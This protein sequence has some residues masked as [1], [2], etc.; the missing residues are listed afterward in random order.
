MA[1][2]LK[3]EKR[4]QIQVLIGLG[5]S[6]RRISATIGIDRDTVSKYRKELKRNP[7]ESIA[8]IPSAI[9]NPPKVPT[10]SAEESAQNPPEV[11][12][13]IPHVSTN[14]TQL[15]SHTETVRAMFLK[16]L[17]AQRIFQDLVEEYGYR[18]SYDSVKRYVRKLRKRIRGFTDRLEH[19]P[20][21]E[22]QVDF[23]KA[24]CKVL[25]DGKYQRPWLFK[26]T[27]SCSKHA[28]EE[29]VWSQDIE[30]FL[31]CHERAFKFF[32]GV[33]EIVTLDNLRAGVLKACLYDPIINQTYLA[34]ATHWGFAANPCIPRMPEHKG[35]VERDIGYT[36]HNALDGREFA[37]LDAAN[38]FLRHWSRRWA[39]TRIHGTTKCQ[40]WK[41]FCEVEQAHLQPL[42]KNDY[43]YFTAAVRKVDVN[44]LVEVDKRYYGVPVQYIG[45]SV[46]A[47]FNQKWVK[48]YFQSQLVITHQ[49]ILLA[50]KMS[51]PASC[52]P[53]W[54]H[55]DLESQERYYCRMA[56]Q[57][58]PAMHTL[59]YKALCSDDVLAI[60]RVRGFLSLAKTYGNAVAEEAASRA[61]LLQTPK[62]P[63]LQQLCI[64]IK[65]G[66]HD[67]VVSTQLLTQ[68]HELIRPLEEYDTLINGERNNICQ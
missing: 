51:R 61:K 60:R 14:S 62:Y 17:S 28:Y 7:P 32:N 29:L 66:Y 6:N 57:I 53:P 3:M 21:R 50:G 56:Q 16:K 64:Q 35:V 48:V 25:K 13:D 59:V 8:Q 11:P 20:G 49:R 67:S 31:R 9:Q 54:K 52:L 46:V 40:V 5:W 18:G 19:L 30:T 10:E 15:Y 36:K 45:S 39:R 55:P 26:M 63:L 1:N 65:N 12:A 33:P 68:T 43:E 47:H 41:L 37:N 22:A 34:F 27:L 44:G 42:A 38:V 2:K 4:Q 24:T 23:G 58:G